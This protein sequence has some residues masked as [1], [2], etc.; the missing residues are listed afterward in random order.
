LI[1]L[2]FMTVARSAI[3]ETINETTVGQ[4]VWPFSFPRPENRG[5]SGTI[6]DSHSCAARRWLQQPAAPVALKAISLT[7]VPIR[8][9]P[10]ICPLTM[11][12]GSL[13]L[14]DGQHLRSGKNPRAGDFGVIR[15]N[16]GFIAGTLAALRRVVP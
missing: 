11:W 1:L 15:V 10:L 5:L 13:F 16:R 14:I 9:R 6:P 7:A 3:N 12:S 8:R 4:F 2:G